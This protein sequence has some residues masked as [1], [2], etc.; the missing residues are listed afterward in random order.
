MR[1]RANAVVKRDSFVLAV[2]PADRKLDSKKAREAL[3]VK[4]LR[5][6]RGCYLISRELQDFRAS[7]LGV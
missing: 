5:L 7:L 4:G 3:G 6:L 2:L 1:W